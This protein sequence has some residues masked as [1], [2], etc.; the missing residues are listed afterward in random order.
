VDLHQPS[1]PHQSLR[2]LRWP[3]LKSIVGYSR[4]NIYYLMKRGEFPQ[5][6]QLGGRAIGWLESEIDE[7][8]RAKVEQSR[9]GESK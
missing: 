8:I 2:I 4:T 9:S 3:E 5:A 6:I 7:W 1:S